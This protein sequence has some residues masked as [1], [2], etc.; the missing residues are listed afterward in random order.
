MQ[1]LKM[2][3]DTMSALFVPLSPAIRRKPPKVL[4]RNQWPDSIEAT[5]DSLMLRLSPEDKAMIRA[6]KRGD[7]IL[8]R[9]GLGGEISSYYGL[10][11]G[12][13]RLFIATCGRRCKPADA[14]AIIIEALWLRLQDS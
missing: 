12:N 11:K 9:H 2:I 10:N 13:L 6:T 4:P 7:L 5:L 14:A 1:A 3:A 8:F